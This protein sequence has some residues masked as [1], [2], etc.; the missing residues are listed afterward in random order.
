MHDFYYQSVIKP[1]GL[2]KG[3]RPQ[4]AEETASLPY[5]LPKS[6]VFYVAL[7]WFREKKSISLMLNQSM[8]RNHSVSWDLVKNK[9]QITMYL[10]SICLSST[11][12]PIKI[13]VGHTGLIPGL[14][15]EKQDF[16]EL[17]LNFKTKTAKLRVQ[18]SDWFEPSDA[19]I[20]CHCDVCES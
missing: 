1:L 19:Y 14:H 3:L 11:L 17:K 13:S 5:K 15:T 10:H 18:F 16:R 8:F 12:F 7:C 6:L 4:E 2:T 20:K 9:D